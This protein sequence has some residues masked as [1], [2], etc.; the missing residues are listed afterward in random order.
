MAISKIFMFLLWVAAA[1]AATSNQTMESSFS[2]SGMLPTR[3]VPSHT[4]VEQATFTTRLGF[5][6]VTSSVN[7]NVANVDYPSPEANPDAVDGRTATK[8]DTPLQTVFLILGVLLALASIVVAVF[9]GHKQLSI[10]R[11]QSTAGRNNRE[12]GD[13]NHDMELGEP[14]ETNDEV[15]TA[16]DLATRSG[17]SVDRAFVRTTLKNGLAP[18]SN[19]LKS[20]VVASWS[21]VRHAGQRSPLDLASPPLDRPSELPHAGHE[22]H[23][24]LDEPHGEDHNMQ[25]PNPCAQG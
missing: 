25:R 22:E 4:I 8:P 5:E 24:R 12:R 2:S 11:N 20:R 6:A 7:V 13:D 16:T 1:T 17:N 21:F 18:I 23:V 14:D 19:A 9:F 3:A 10:T 15:R